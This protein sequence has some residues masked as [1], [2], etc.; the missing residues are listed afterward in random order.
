MGIQ[1]LHSSKVALEQSVG[2]APALTEPH[3]GRQR[4]EPAGV[5]NN[6]SA[7]L[8]KPENRPPLC[9]YAAASAAACAAASTTADRRVGST[10]A[11]RPPPRAGAHQATSPGADVRSQ[12]TNRPVVA[13]LGLLGLALP[14]AHLHH[15]ARGR[16]GGVRVVSG[17]RPSRLRGPPPHC[18]RW[19]AATQG[20][21][22]RP[23][24]PS[25]APTTPN[26][27]IRVFGVLL[28]R[29]RGAGT[30]G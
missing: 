14:G 30:G 12:A 11:T 10:N 21:S 17:A 16:G 6:R 18:P 20:R 15:G 28:Q 9:A 5:E 13:P 24:S 25:Q 23:P 22:P 8:S 29:D 1:G 4:Q 26:T 3:D 2:S 19:L 7:V 27:H